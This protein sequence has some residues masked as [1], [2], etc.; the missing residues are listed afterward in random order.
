MHMS[1]YTYADKYKHSRWLTD[2]LTQ[3][4]WDSRMKQNLARSQT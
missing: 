1:L 4:D 2:S 3:E